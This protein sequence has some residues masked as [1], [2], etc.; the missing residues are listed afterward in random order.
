M[1][2]AK[3][4][5]IQLKLQLTDELQGNAK[6]FPLHYPTFVFSIIIDLFI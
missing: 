1:Q 2:Q 6:D 5:H 3:E 4:Y